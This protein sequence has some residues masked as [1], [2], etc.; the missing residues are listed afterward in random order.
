MRIAMII[1]SLLGFLLFLPMG[2]FAAGP[3]NVGAGLFSGVLGGI[4]GLLLTLPFYF[5]F[6]TDS[7]QSLVDQAEPIRLETPATVQGL[8][9]LDRH[10]VFD[11]NIAVF[12][13]RCIFTN[14]VVKVLRPFT[15][16]DVRSVSAG[17]VAIVN[18]KKQLEYLP[19]SKEWLRNRQHI[20]T[21]VQR[22]AIAVCFAGIIASITGGSLTGN[23][24]LFSVLTSISVIGLMISLVLH[25]LADFGDRQ[26]LYS[27]Y[28]LEDGRIIIQDA[29]PEFLANLPE[30]KAGILHG[31]MGIERLK[32]V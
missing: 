21:I 22:I 19:V 3:I 28:F 5:V 10:L 31:V 15:I 18:V 8:W 4:I 14:K 2:L 16:G 1:C 32:E 7:K 26:E 6:R 27:S 11:P 13:Q 20:S 9:R 25:R 23:W 30:L 29:H 12:P 17:P 24:E